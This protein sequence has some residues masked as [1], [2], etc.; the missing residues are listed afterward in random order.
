M[1]LSPSSFLR[2]VLCELGPLNNLLIHQVVLSQSSCHG[3]SSSG[4]KQP[5]EWQGSH[6]KIL[7]L[8]STLTVYSRLDSLDKRGTIASCF[9]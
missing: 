7:K 2:Q 5:L 3:G 1:H 9:V 8:N 4:E 6:A